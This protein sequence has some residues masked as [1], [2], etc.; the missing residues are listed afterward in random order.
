MIVTGLD[1]VVTRWNHHAELLYGWSP[2]EAVGR[3]VVELIV[4]SG[5]KTEAETIMQ[6][7][8]EGRGWAGEFQVIRKDGTPIEIYA[9]DSLVTDERGRPTGIVGVSFDITERK[10]AEQQLAIQHGVTRALAEAETLSE[11]APMILQAICE[12]TGWRVG[13]M[14]ILDHGR[15]VLRPVEVWQADGSATEAFAAHTL[16]REFAPGEGLPGRVFQSREPRWIPDV[17]SAPEF[18]R[19]ASAREAGL[20]SGVFF[21]IVMGRDVLGVLEFFDVEIRKPDGP[22]LQM[23]ENIGGQV[24]QFIERVE[25]QDVLRRTEARRRAILEAS[26]DAIV[27]MDQDGRITE[28]NRSAERTFG[29]SRDE[30]IGL[31]LA[32]TLIPPYLRERHRTALK[33]YQETGESTLLG[34]RMELTALRKD[35]TEFPVELALSRIEIDGPALYKGA[36]R[37]ITERKHAE[38]E[39]ARILAEEQL[40][41]AQ[42]EA[43]QRHLAFLAEAGTVLSSAADFASALDTLGRLAVSL[44][45]DLCLIDVLDDDGEMRR[46]VAVHADPSKD[47]LTQQLQRR[48][49]PKRGGPHPAA[50]VIETGTSEFSPDMTEEFLRAT[51]RDEEHFHIT[52]QLG[53]KSYMCVPLIARGRILGTITLVSTDEARRFGPADVTL[54]EDLARRTAMTVDNVRLLESEQRARRRA[55]RAADRTSVLQS[56]TA[57]LSEALSSEQVTSVVLNQAAGQLGAD[58][59]VIGVV[60]PGGTQ[61]ETINAIG[62]SAE[63]LER[64]RVTPVDSSYPLASAVRTRGPVFVQSREELLERYAD[65]AGGATSQA[66]A[67]VPI[68]M[69]DRAVGALFLGFDRARSFSDED[70]QFLQALG[71]QAGHA[72]ERAR[73]YE[74][75]RSARAEAERARRQLALLAEASSALAAGIQDFERM[76][77]TTARL[78]VPQFADWCAVD[79]LREDGSIDRVALAHTDPAKEELGRNLQRRFPADPEAPRGVANVLQT[80]QSEMIPEITDE[81]LVGAAADEES[82]RI[83]RA[84]GLKSMMVVPLVARGRTLGAMT[85]V[86]A[87][88][89][90][91]Y[92]AEDLVLAEDL[93]RRAA[94]AVD[95]ARLYHERSST[96]RTLQQT[97][98]PPELP[99]IP[100]I[101]LAALYRPTGE[102]NEIG[103]DFYD[104]FETGEGS[105]GL[106]IGDVCGKGVEAAAITGL[107]RHTVR[108]VAIRERRP[109]SILGA[110][111]EAL[112]AQTTD[113]RFCTVC[114]VRV[115]SSGQ[116]ARLTVCSGGH[117]LPVIVRAH[118]SVETVG[119]PGTLLGIF[120]EPVLPDVAVDLGPGDAMVLYTDGVTEERDADSMFGETGLHQALR[121][122]A[123]RDAQGIAAAVADAVHTFR[124]EA[125]RDDIAIV[126][127]R[128]VP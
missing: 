95:N 99:A 55:E 56:V 61:I 113:E 97:L 102:G 54:A 17:E 45:A 80:G 44:L 87:E 10:R 115:V 21:P 92:G 52:Q 12:R 57:A 67:T 32:D 59:G 123:G 78:A 37:D 53:M 101:E 100:G 91:L 15:G 112:A 34:Q 3:N 39:L 77:S 50:R 7:V 1:G 58:T 47:R 85:F 4:P 88:S 118:G 31:D 42:M 73:L 43:A 104:L 122:A 33:R 38:A 41:R 84:I 23:L 18:A 107:V 24:G 72:L 20:H 75:E 127:L 111:N 94:L 48:Y 66:F 40:A 22:L 128:V 86:S 46:M 103:G 117:P 63:L 25:A 65:W 64:H 76:L 26:L 69:E 106:V 119:Q 29:Y 28:F 70:I 124:P 98:L 11:A 79:L 6:D 14:W 126:A 90:R 35:G 114:Y 120:P 83:I 96:A 108:A 27:A 19:G 30:V 2:E 116:G 109:S 62:Y 60:R 121:S 82:L 81:M 5:A 74:A 68:M 71:R 105:W 13:G 110:L 36:I 93:A 51:T 16:K 49:P 125:P 89:G 8:A 9:T